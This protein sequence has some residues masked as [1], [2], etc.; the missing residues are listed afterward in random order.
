MRATQARR[1]A[2]RPR[3][4]ALSLLRCA[5]CALAVSLLCMTAAPDCARADR[6]AGLAGGVAIPYKGAVGWNVLG[7][8]GGHMW[9]SK[10]FLGGA[11]FEFKRQDASPAGGGSSDVP[12]D[13]YNVRLLGRFVF[14]PKRLTPYFGGGG[15][16]GAIHTSSTATDPKELGLSANIVGLVGVNLPLAGGRIGLF[17][18]AR[19]G[20][21]WDLTGDFSHVQRKGFD[22]FAGVGGIR[23]RF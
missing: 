16:L 3:A 20:F 6:Y 12:V 15:G 18:E 11:E 13:L 14:A 17:S 23:F 4:V 5:S 10:H 8:I 7:E 9:G 19:F 21:T 1:T 22:G 2:A